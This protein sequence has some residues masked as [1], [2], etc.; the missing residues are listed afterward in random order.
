MRPRHECGRLWSHPFHDSPHA[1]GIV[2]ANVLRPHIRPHNAPVHLPPPIGVAAMS[3]YVRLHEAPAHEP[4][5]VVVFHLDIGIVRHPSDRARQVSHSLKGMML[6][7]PDV[8]HRAYRRAAQS[9]S[10]APR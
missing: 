4:P 6:A 7:I 10:R 5:Q 1:A 9:P 8:R 2:F 3:A